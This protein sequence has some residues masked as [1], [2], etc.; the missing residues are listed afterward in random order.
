MFCSDLSGILAL[1]L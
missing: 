1:Y